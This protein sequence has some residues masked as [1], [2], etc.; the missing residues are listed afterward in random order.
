[1]RRLVGCVLLS[2]C[3]ALAGAAQT[4]QVPAAAGKSPVPSVGEVVDV[5]LINIDVVVT[6]A[7]GEHVRGLTR[8]ELGGSRHTAR[9]RLSG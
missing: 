1:M 2:V 8:A 7:N 4:S 5:E 3:S 6:D 9:R